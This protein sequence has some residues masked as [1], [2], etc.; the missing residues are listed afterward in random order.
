MKLLQSYQ[1]HDPLWDKTSITCISSWED[2]ERTNPVISFEFHHIVFDFRDLVNVEERRGGCLA[3]ILP[4][5]PMEQ[6]RESRV[7]KDRL[8]DKRI[9]HFTRSGSL[10]IPFVKTLVGELENCFMGPEILDE[11]NDA[12][13]RQ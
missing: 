4:Y 7:R 6:D 3:V 1:F 8:I 9:D 2:G 13:A 12:G 10:K 11:F 5:N